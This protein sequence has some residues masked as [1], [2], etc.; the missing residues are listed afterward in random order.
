MLAAPGARRG[1]DAEM[2]LQGGAV[3]LQG[4]ART[5]VDDGAA[6]ENHRPG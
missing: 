1:G 4:G 6:L 5:L 2:L 3:G